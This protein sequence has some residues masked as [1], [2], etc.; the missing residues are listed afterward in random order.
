[1]TVRLHLIVPAT[2]PAAS[3]GVVGADDGLDEPNRDAV[4]R[5]VRPWP[6]N[7]VATCAPHRSCVETAALLGLH[8]VADPRV[9]DW[10]LGA[11]TGRSLSEIATTSPQDLESWL[12]DPDFAVDG[13]ESL[14][15]L[16][17][18]VMLWL[19]ALETEGQPRLVTVAPTAVV[20][21]I[22]VNVLGAPTATFWRLDLE[23]VASV[24]VSLRAGRR[25]VRW[26]AGDKQD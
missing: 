2:T 6:D 13:G 5:R 19:D 3:R 12:T 16:R 26:S 10:E 7:L 14:H 18:R 4:L 9:R 8:A 15:Q 1:M 25:A 22:L 24:Y 21:A 20:R 17:S 23:P 11:W